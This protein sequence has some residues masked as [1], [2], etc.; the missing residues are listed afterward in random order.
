MTE[1]AVRLVAD[2]PWLVLLV[3]GSA[4]LSILVWRRFQL[5]AMYVRGTREIPLIERMVPRNAPL[6]IAFALFLTA[7]V[8][9]SG[10]ALTPDR[11]AFLRSAEWQVQ[12]F[13]MIAHLITL[14]SFIRVFATNFRVGIRTLAA[15]E[16]EVRLWLHRTLGAPGMLAAIIIASPFAAA[17]YR[18]LVS[19]RYVRLGGPGAPSAADHLMWLIWAAEWAANAFVWVIL[20]A[21]LFKNSALIRR[22]G[23]VDPIEVV[24]HEKRYRPFLRMSAQGASVLLAFS[25]MT[26]LYIWYAGGELTDYLGLAITCA[27]LTIGF[28]VPWMLLRGKVR[29]NVMAERRSLERAVASVARFDAGAELTPDRPV[30]LAA[31]QYRLDSAL[32]LLRLSHLERLHLN[33]G[34][35]EAR[36]LLVRISAPLLTIVWQIFQHWE[37][38]AARLNGLVKSFLAALAQVLR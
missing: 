26:V 36:A 1:A 12:P 10:Y 21:F 2:S 15:P 24:V 37:Q 31:L 14:G 27:L 32:V 25:V 38:V 18:F 6:G 28:F 33:L 13:Y 20:L 11:D 5:D 8:W 22:H 29:D 19:D 7:V 9:M 3:I 35:T 16:A 4:V 30:D 23:F 17:D 34:A